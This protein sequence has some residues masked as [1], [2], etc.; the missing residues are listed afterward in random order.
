M[1]GS[2]DID[3]NMVPG[4]ILYLDVRLLVVVVVVVVVVGSPRLGKTR[5]VP[6]M[7][8]AVGCRAFT[9][10]SLCLC[11][12]V[13]P[14]SFPTRPFNDM[15]TLRYMQQVK[16]LFTMKTWQYRKVEWI[17]NSNATVIDL[18]GKVRLFS[19]SSQT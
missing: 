4:I 18:V 11:P 15:L 3:R 8:K 1:G 14:T 13:S 9:D 16:D 7:G 5:T 19:R 10:L 12:F 2:A 6:G 17:K